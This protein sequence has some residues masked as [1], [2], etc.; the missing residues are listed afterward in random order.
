MMCFLQISNEYGLAIIL[1]PV[2]GVCF[3]LIVA[4]VN[5]RFRNTANMVINTEVTE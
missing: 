4:T 5:C 1:L 3:T 2:Q